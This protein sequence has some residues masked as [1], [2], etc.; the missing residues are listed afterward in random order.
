M[1]AVSG[2]CFD[3]LLIFLVVIVWGRIVYKK[4]GRE[5]GNVFQVYFHLG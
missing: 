3:T 1:I 2:S 4:K 5:N